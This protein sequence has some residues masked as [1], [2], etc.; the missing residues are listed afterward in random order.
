MVA[1]I[2]STTAQLA[3][4]MFFG[5]IITLASDDE[6]TNRTQKLNQY[7]FILFIIIAFG[8][9]TTTIRGW[10]YTLIGERLV[11]RLR[12][13]LFEKIISQDISFF[14]SNKTGELLNRLSSDTTVIQSCLSVNISMGLRSVAEIVVSIILLF[15]T[16]WKLTLV[17]MAIVP[18]LVIIVSFYGR[19]TRKLTKQ[20]QDALARAAETGAETIS[21]IRI[22]KSFGSEDWEYQKY[23]HNVHRSYEKGAAK[24][25]AYGIFAG[26]IGFLAG[27][28][29]LVVVYYGATLV[30]DGH[31]KVGELT[32]F[33]LYS[34]YIAVG[35]GIFSSLYTEFMNALG[36]SERFITYY[37]FYFMF[38]R[39]YISIE[40]FK[41]STLILLYH[42]IKACGRMMFVKV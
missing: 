40:S 34:I 32:A 5:Y 7:S 21:N 12:T 41:S 29:I 38:S 27:L 28:A 1:L 35:M 37:Y 30:I 8:G 17:M 33:I 26:G 16:S 22:M 9:I 2:C 20:Y 42:M 25:F 3:Q 23:H 24:S 13:R 14:D 10:L 39:N 19:F 18:V 6:T 15:I 11:K 4:P 31:L 36:A